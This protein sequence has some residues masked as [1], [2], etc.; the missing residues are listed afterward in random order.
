MNNNNTPTMTAS[1]L[2]NAAEQWSKSDQEQHIAAMVLCDKNSEQYFVHYAG[3]AKDIA[4]A[5]TVLM[6]EDPETAFNI[7]AAVSVIAHKHFNPAVIVNVE[8]TAAKIAEM[9]R[10][11]ATD[12]DIRNAIMRDQ[13]NQTQKRNGNE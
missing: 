13:Q 6:D 5:V 2:I 3:L 7:F 8:H 9:R 1:Q 10:I 4:K 11:G 12:D